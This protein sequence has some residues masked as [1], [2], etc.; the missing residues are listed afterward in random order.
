MFSILGV[1]LNIGSY[2]Y[3]LSTNLK[4]EYP[5]KIVTGTFNS[6]TSNVPALEEHGL[7]GCR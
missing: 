5:N 7:I 2:S 6:E 3:G 4:M 1:A